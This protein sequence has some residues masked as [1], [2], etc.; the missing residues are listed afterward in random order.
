VCCHRR[1]S[2]LLSSIFCLKS[3]LTGV[4]VWACR[5]NWRG[6]PGSLLDGVYKMMYVVFNIAVRFK[7]SFE[8]ECLLY[9]FGKAP[10]PLFWKLNS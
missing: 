5:G 8:G 9:R 4:L 7:G 3:R 6:E 10:N 2:L 1:R